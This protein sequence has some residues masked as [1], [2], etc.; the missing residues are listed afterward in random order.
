MMKKFAVVLMA[1][2]AVTLTASEAAVKNVVQQYIAN[3]LKMDARVFDYIA[4]NCT[5]T[6][7]GKV[8]TFA[9]F[10]EEFK[11]VAPQF[12]ML[13]QVVNLTND[14]EILTVAFKATG[15]NPALIANMPADQKK[16]LAVRIKNQFVQL[17]QTFQKMLDSFKINTVVINGNKATVNAGLISVAGSTVK[18]VITL[19]KINGKWLIT[20][21][22]D[23]N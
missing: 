16:Q 20:K 15:N 12:E 11:V 6:S 17:N 22:T 5:I 2:C 7:N 23:Q 21:A 3:I 9:Q 14:D 10:K 18:L 4:P 8:K 1:L 13:R 19:E